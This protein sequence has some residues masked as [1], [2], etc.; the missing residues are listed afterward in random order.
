ML[1]YRSGKEALPGS[2]RNRQSVVNTEPEPG[3]PSPGTR[4]SSEPANQ[5]LALCVCV[6]VCVCFTSSALC[7]PSVHLV[8]VF[9]P[10]T[11]EA[12]FWSLVLV[13]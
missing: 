11:E 10:S 4:H 9:R 2:E 5:D 12:L 1:E 7:P 8:S 13:L 6:S 3:L